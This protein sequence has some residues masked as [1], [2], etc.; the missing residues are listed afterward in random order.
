VGTA[1]AR[2]EIWSYGL[3]NPWRFSF[4]RA[5]GDLYIGEVGRAHWE[6]INRAR[7]ADGGGRGINYGWSVMEGPD[8]QH[9]DCDPTGLTLPTVTYSHQT[10][11]AVIGGYVYRGQALPSL[12]G[13]YLFGDFCQGWVKSFPADAESPEAVDQPAL[14][15]GEPITSFGEDDA[16]E[17]YIMTVSG[18]VL[19]IAP[20][21]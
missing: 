15:P 10:G 5:N 16:G 13:Q 14:S 1:G 9:R 11:C 21:Q 3:R 2:T 7:A 12:Q 20:Q 6:E 18:S 17:L 19:K 8:C 4:D